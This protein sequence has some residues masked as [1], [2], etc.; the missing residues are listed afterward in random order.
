[1]HKTFQEFFDQNNLTVNNNSAHGVLNGYEVNYSINNLSAP[2]KVHI[3]FYATEEQ[4][5]AIT[6]ALKVNTDK[7]TFY[8]LD[9]YGITI[10]VNNVWGMGKTAEKLIRLSKDLCDILTNNG[11]LGA[12]YCPI[13]GRYTT[14]EN[15]RAR[16]I[17]GNLITIDDDCAN[18]I[19]EAITQDNLEFENA[20]NNYLKGFVGALIGA[21]AGAVV[22]IILNIVG[23]Y[24]GISS[25][26]SFFVGILLYRKFGGK[27]NKM[28]IVIVTVTTFVTMILAVLAI[29]VALAGI[30]AIDT[31]Y[32]VF[33]AFSICM[34]DEEFSSA[35]YVDLAMTLL[36][37][38][39]GC[40]S[41]I[42]KTARDIKRSKNI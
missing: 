8:F 20:P 2:L 16:N 31:Q 38:V 19:N 34:A 10:S 11:A 37:T 22:A 39:V 24:A 3:A 21:V 18:Q 15:S 12:G 41:E 40:V 17:D 5:N 36:F 42:V 29:Y 9:K 25:F 35:F 14:A 26:V 4:K 30:A 32:S 27:P 33:E 13:C 7:A 28:M 6:N 1:M 23:F